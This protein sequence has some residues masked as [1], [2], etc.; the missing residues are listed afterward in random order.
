MKFF[1]AFFKE[2]E[3][4]FQLAYMNTST[5]FVLQEQYMD[6][7]IHPD[8][9]R[10]K[11]AQKQGVIDNA[12]RI[13]FPELT[14]MNEPNA[15]SDWSLINSAPRR[16][17]YHCLGNYPPGN[18]EPSLTICHIFFKKIIPGFCEGFFVKSSTTPTNYTV[19]ICKQTNSMSCKCKNY[20]RHY[21]VTTFALIP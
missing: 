17:K 14:E 7:S 18:L 6:S 12:N 16:G 8:Y 10:M 20:E 13:T 2:Q 15:I 19:E 1:L 3:F 21:N 11:A 5:Q 4:S 9:D